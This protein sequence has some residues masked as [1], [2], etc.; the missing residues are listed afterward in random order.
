[1]IKVI[2]DVFERKRYMKLFGDRNKKVPG[3]ECQGQWG[4]TQVCTFKVSF[5]CMISF[6][7]F[8]EIL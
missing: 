4:V 7:L 1:M 2:L 3:L 6:Q 8:G 5:I